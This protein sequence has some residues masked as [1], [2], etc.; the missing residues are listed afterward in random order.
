VVQLL[1]WDRSL[2]TRI[3]LGL[4]F[5]TMIKIWASVIKSEHFWAANLRSR[6]QLKKL[7][8]IF[9]SESKSQTHECYIDY[10][11]FNTGIVCI[12]IWHVYVYGIVCIWH[13]MYMYVCI[14]VLGFFV[15]QLRLCINFDKKGL[16]YILGDFFINLVVERFFKVCTHNFYPIKQTI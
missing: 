16:G 15:P 12:C 14:E 2:K 11:V 1:R 10:N 8:E 13:C 7:K 5:I 9:Q 6:H 4:A 3:I